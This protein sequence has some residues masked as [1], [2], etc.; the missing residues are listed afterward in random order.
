M[1]VS[2][3]DH[4]CPL[5]SPVANISIGYTAPN[6]I[7]VSWSEK[8]LNSSIEP[9]FLKV[10]GFNVQEST[11]TNIHLQ[12]MVSGTHTHIKLLN[13]SKTSVYKYALM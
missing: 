4:N 12:F 13:R 8:A 6:T 3:V 2:V 9:L 11:S 7:K 10:Y 5:F 1:E